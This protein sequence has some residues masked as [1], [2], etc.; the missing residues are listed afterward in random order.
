MLVFAGRVLLKSSGRRTIQFEQ[1]TRNL[2]KNGFYSRDALKD[3]FDKVDLDRSGSLELSVLALL[4]TI[5]H[6]V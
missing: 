3:C 2:A 4:R 5:C 1:L 6:S